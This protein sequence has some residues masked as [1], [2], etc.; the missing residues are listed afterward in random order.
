MRVPELRHELEIRGLD[1]SGTKVILLSRLQYALDNE[2]R[3]NETNASV[4]RQGN[5][6]A[7][8]QIDTIDHTTES[9]QRI[10]I[11]GK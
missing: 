11:S 3:E 9:N 6:D 1:F 4:L 5:D 8:M 10:T 7:E 2:S